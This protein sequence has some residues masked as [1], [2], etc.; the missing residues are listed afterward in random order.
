MQL[1]DA[2]TFIVLI[3]PSQ[4]HVIFRMMKTGSKRIL[5]H[6]DPVEIFEDG[7]RNTDIYGGYISPRVVALLNKE[8]TFLV[9]LQPKITMKQRRIIQQFMEGK[10]DKMIAA[11]LNISYQ[12]MRTHRKN[13][14]RLFN[15]RS[16]GE[17]YALLH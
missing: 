11:D 5:L 13:I 12:T 17:L 14:Y 2:F 7:I 16:Q 8:N 15:V 10:S 9:Q 4:I 6:D 1:V 3:H